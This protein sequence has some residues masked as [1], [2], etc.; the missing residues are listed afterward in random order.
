ML[1]A[2]RTNQVT[3]VRPNALAAHEVTTLIEER[4]AML[5]RGA[6]H[7]TLLGLEIG[8][9]AEAVHAA[10]VELARNLRPARLD[11]LGISDES[12]AAQR[13]LAQ[14]GIAF[15]VLTDRILRP[16]YMASLPAG[17]RRAAGRPA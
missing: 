5:D 4:T 3:A 8:A 13:L 14:V 6:D 12:F 17:R 9:P 16:E 15:T 2:F 10:Y 1:D 7:F 11:E